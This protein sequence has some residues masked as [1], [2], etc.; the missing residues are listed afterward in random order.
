[1]SGFLNSN[2]SVRGGIDCESINASFAHGG[3][4]ALAE[5][6]LLEGTFLQ[7]KASD[8]IQLFAP[9]SIGSPVSINLPD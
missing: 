1:M 7:Y 8:R 4:T 5:F 2:V 3:L 9:G 6:I